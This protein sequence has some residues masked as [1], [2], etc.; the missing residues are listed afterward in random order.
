ME[1]PCPLSQQKASGM[2]QTPL[3]KGL[4]RPGVFSRCPQRR[5]I[6][7][8]L[9]ES[10]VARIPDGFCRVLWCLPPSPAWLYRHNLIY[11]GNKV[12]HTLQR[13]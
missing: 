10:S 3:G 5:A 6:C 2:G 9:W 12:N 11:L 13:F 1:V 4:Q 7:H 8:E